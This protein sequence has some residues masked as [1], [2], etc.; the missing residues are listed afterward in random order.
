[1]I[2]WFE[3]AAVGCGLVAA[4]LAWQPVHGYECQTLELAQHGNSTE[5]RHDRGLLWKI[6]REG[7]PPSYLFG[8]IHVSDPAIIDLPDAIV[9]ALQQSERFV[10]EARLNG[11]DMLAFAQEM[12]FRDGTRLSDLLEAELYRDTEQLL[13]RYGIPPMAVESLKPWAAFMTLNMPPEHGLPLDLVLKNRAREYGLPVDGLETVAEQAAVFE[14][15]SLDTQIELLTD[16]VC[17]YEV[18]QGDMADMKKLY[19]ERDLEG[20]FGYHNRYH[21]QSGDQ[22][23]DLMQRLLW[24][25]NRTMAERMQPILEQGTAFIAVGAMHLPGER[26]VLGLLEQAG[27]RVTAI[28]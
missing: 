19:L 17:H 11:D 16:S 2:N 23:Q 5:V 9:E 4:L 1:M 7:T 13:V 6:V 21:L 28:Y 25:R 3:K 15:L 18:L 14:N 24:D 22:Y 20:L 27:Y 12:F 8:T 10:M 26:G